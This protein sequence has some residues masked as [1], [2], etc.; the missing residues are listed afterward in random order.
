[1]FDIVYIKGGNA[2][3][4]IRAATSSSGV[5]DPGVGPTPNDGDICDLPLSVRRK[6]LQQAVRT[7][8]NRVE[9]VQCMTVTS[10]DTTIRKNQLESFFNTVTLAGEEGL[11]VKDLTSKYLIGE[12]SR[13]EAKW[14]KM[15]PEYGDQTTDLDLIVIGE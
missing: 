5:Q 12:K 14:V 8:E 9:V 7:I 3:N 15:K 11:V 4:I 1:M 10:L 2:A 6:I 13:K